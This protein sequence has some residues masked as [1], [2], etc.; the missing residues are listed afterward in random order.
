MKNEQ[1]CMTLAELQVELGK[2]IRILSNGID[3]TEADYKKAMII[4]SIAKQM[5]N[6]ADVILRYSKMT[7][8]DNL[9]G[10]LIECKNTTKKN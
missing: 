9:K 6:N 7:L 3:L 8:N 2:Q 1:K 4:C 10:T 5:V